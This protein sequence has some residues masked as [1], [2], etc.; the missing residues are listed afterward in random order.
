MPKQIS[1]VDQDGPTPTMKW[2]VASGGVATINPGTPTKFSSAGA[3]VPMADGD[4]STSQRFTGIAKGTS[5]D[6]ASAAGVVYT[7][8]PL[9]GINYAGVA[10]SATGANTQ[11]RID[12]LLGARLVFDL[13][14]TVGPGQ[15]GKWTIDA[16]AGDGST[17]CLVVIGG[18]Y[19]SNTLYFVYRNTGVFLGA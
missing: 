18:D 17:N 4:G 16:A 14:G 15:T 3:I 10:K 6:T 9:P 11:A 19:T 5:T 13:T 7:F 1:I 2:L 12:A 8:L